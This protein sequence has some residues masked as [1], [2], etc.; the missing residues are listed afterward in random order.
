M[1]NKMERRL[2]L[3]HSTALKHKLDVQEPGEADW[4]HNERLSVH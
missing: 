3:S 1:S 2:T 4:S